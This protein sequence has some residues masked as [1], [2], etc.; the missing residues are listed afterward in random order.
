MQLTPIE[1]VSIPVVSGIQRL[2]VSCKTA[3]TPEFW[4]AILVNHW[5]W[6]PAPLPRVPCCEMLPKH[7]VVS[8]LF[9]C[10]P[11]D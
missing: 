6:R 2:W 11:H 7:H 8:F 1:I 10:F 3:T 9:R 4:S 5:G